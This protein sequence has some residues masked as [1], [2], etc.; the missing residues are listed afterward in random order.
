MSKLIAFRSNH[1]ET[2]CGLAQIKRG[3]LGKLAHILRSGA[4]PKEA[5]ETLLDNGLYAIHD[6]LI[7]HGWQ[8]VGVD[9]EDGRA[10][11]R[12]VVGHYFT[13]HHLG[14]CIG[15]HLELVIDLQRLGLQPESA[16]LPLQALLNI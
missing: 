11:H 12:I 8:H 16:D 3:A 5:I 4:L 6:K 1:L 7:G 9:I 2:V 13:G 15:I 14:L 10:H